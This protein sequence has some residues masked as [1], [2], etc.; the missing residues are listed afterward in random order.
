MTHT[1]R[2]EFPEG[3]SLGELL[4]A[5]SVSGRTPFQVLHLARLADEFDVDTSTA[6]GLTGALLDEWIRRAEDD[7]LSHLMR[8]C[9]GFLKVT[10]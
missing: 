10:P 9:Q 2:F 7:L 5:E 4:K 8:D 1:V 3:L 6:D